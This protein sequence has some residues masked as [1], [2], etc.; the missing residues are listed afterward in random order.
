[1]RTMGSIQFR[2]E[3]FLVVENRLVP[4]HLVGQ[5]DE[6]V[7]MVRGVDSA[8]DDEDSG[9][10]TVELWRGDQFRD[11]REISIDE[12]ND[13]GGAAFVRL[14]WSEAPERSMRLIVRLVMAGR[15]L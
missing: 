15:E 5:G 3:L 4:A 10:P 9:A 13:S 7:V 12:L 8:I 11:R 1:M 14:T 2:C 6:L